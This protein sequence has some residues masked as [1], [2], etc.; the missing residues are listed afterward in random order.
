MS[1]RLH[2]LLE[3]ALSA[4]F[5]GRARARRFD[6]IFATGVMPGMCRSVFQ[7]S[8]EAAQS[9]PRT[10]HLGYDHASAGDLYQDRLDRVSPGDFPNMVWLTKAFAAGVTR[11]FDLGGHVGASYYAYQRYMSYPAQLR[12]ELLDVPAVAVRGR[13]IAAVRDARRA[14]SFVDDFDGAARADLL[15]SSGCLRYLEE[16]LATKL[17]RLPSRP[18][19]VLINLVPMHP[20][21]DFWTVQSIQDAF[22]TYHVQRDRDFFGDMQSLGYTLLDRWINA[23]KRCTVKFRPEHSVEGYV[24]AVF[25]RPSAA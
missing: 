17:A 13:E 14:L 15:F 21:Y 16:S 1:D 18:E 3:S 25:R 23:E 6:R 10:L 4:P 20:D 9:A 11:V 24:G 2:E 8:A 22:C 19:W 12:W 5:I 7:T